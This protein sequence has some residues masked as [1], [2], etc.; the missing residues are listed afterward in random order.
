MSVRYNSSGY[1]RE[2]ESTEIPYSSYTIAPI[3]VRQQRACRSFFRESQAANSQS[4][5]RHWDEIS[6]EYPQIVEPLE[7]ADEVTQLKRY[8]ACLALIGAQESLRKAITAMSRLRRKD[9]WALRSFLNELRRDLEL[10][11]K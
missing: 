9:R 7:P 4:P 1:F 3:V 10:L 6:I 11:A 5:G 8:E 2:Y